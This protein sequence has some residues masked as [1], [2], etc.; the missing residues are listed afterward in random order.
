VTS[1]PD[2][3]VLRLLGGAPDAESGLTRYEPGGTL[4]GLVRLDSLRT[5]QLRGVYVVARWRAAYKGQVDVG[6]GR[7]L[8]LHHGDLPPG[9]SV[10][11]PFEYPL[12]GEPWS[13]AGRLIT[14]EWELEAR[15][16]VA[17][18]ADQRATVAF[19]LAPPADP[20]LLNYAGPA[21]TKWEGPSPR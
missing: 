14:I 12:P 16:D 1:G 11:L 21:T 19:I 17:M 6:A 20:S 4:P 13:Y 8:Q 10:E 18:G 2:L 3:P 5:I 9:P 15:C 7:E